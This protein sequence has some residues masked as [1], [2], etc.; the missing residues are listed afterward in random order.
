MLEEDLLLFEKEDFDLAEYVNM[1][2]PN[3][4][5]LSGL[6]DEIKWIDE[7]LLIL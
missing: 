7:Q 4:E 1:K 6:D 3:E 5:S 2:F